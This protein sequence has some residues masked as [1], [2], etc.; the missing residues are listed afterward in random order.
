MPILTVEYILGSDMIHTKKCCALITRKKGNHNV[1][2][3]ILQD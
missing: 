2:Y 1:S 3:S